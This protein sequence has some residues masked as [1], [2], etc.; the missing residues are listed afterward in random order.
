MSSY[1]NLTTGECISGTC[2][3]LKGLDG[4][5]SPMQ[6]VIPI[7]IL[8]LCFFTLCLMIKN[9]YDYLKEREK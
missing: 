6:T 2:Q 8:L 3:S 7:A 1:I 9:R 4:F 5:S